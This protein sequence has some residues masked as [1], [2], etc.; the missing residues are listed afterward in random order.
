MP[1]KSTDEQ[2]AYVDIHSVYGFCN[3]NGR[4]AVMDAGNDA[5]F[6]EFHVARHLRSHAALLRGKT[7]DMGEFT[8]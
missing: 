8:T 6:A 5:H 4:A 3:G 1:N 7:N 2:Q